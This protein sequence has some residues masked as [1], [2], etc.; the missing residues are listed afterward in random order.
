MRN[1]ASLVSIGPYST[2]I[3][4]NLVPILTLQVSHVGA[5]LCYV[6]PS[7]TFSPINIF[8]APANTSL[9]MAFNPTQDYGQP[10]PPSYYLLQLVQQ[11]HATMHHIFPTIQLNTHS[12]SHARSCIC[13]VVTPQKDHCGDCLNKHPSGCV[14]PIVLLRSKISVLTSGPDLV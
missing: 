1:R 10:L 4:I 2:T 3:Q 11:L 13:E 6:G 12:C 14:S 7:V 8:S 9:K 5:R